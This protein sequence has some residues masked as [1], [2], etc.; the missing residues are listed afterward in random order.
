ME[1][2]NE[3]EKEENPKNTTVDDHLKMD[4]HEQFPCSKN[5]IELSEIWLF[6]RTLYALPRILRFYHFNNNTYI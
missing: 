6:N 4:G 5:S 2:R 1:E 3:E